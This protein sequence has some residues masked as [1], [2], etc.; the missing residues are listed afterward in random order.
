MK[1]SAN[2]TI[3][4][5]AT[6]VALLRRFISQRS[7]LQFGN[8]GDI[9]SFRS[10]QRGITKAGQTANILLSAVELDADVSAESIL[11]AA[12]SAFSGRLSFEG[13]EAGEWRISYCTG[14][15]FPTE[16]RNAACAVCA[17]ALWDAARERYATE[18]GNHEGSGEWLRTS[19]RRMFGRSIQKAW[20]D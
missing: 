19:F 3:P 18:M 1:T 10:E 8:Y 15:Y 20:F 14:Q 5:K 17:S 12:K 16:Y 11:Q 13:N 2:T 7:G 9:R 4:S 6:L